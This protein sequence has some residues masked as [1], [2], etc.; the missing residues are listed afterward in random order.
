MAE[1]TE[2][3]TTVKRGDRVKR[4]GGVIGSRRD[5][6]RIWR[7]CG[8]A[9]GGSATAHLEKEVSKGDGPRKGP[10]LHGAYEVSRG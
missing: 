9:G 8:L 7:P 6:R 10:G 5:R 4:G 2:N 3:A 1:D